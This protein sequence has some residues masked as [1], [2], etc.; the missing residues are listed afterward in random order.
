M[1][2]ELLTPDEVATLYRV[3]R[4]TVQRWI[5]S[6]ELPALQVGNQYRIRRSDLD[7][8]VR[9]VGSGKKGA[10]NES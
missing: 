7:N 3:T 6:G 9:E 2:Q 4:N 1:N 8:F 5:K 10:V